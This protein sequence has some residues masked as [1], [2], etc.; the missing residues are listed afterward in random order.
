MAFYSRLALQNVKPLNAHIFMTLCSSPFLPVTVLRIA[1]KRSFFRFS[2]RR[3]LT[4]RT[5][6]QSNTQNRPKG[7]YKY[8]V[9]DNCFTNVLHKRIFF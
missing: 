3:N 7:I 5:G 2:F 1:Q 6:A 8:M 9:F 4:T